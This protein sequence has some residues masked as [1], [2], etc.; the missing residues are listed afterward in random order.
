MSFKERRGLP[1]PSER[2]GI[3]KLCGIALMSS[4]LFIHPSRHIC[5]PDFDLK[6]HISHSTRLQ[7]SPFKL[8]L[9]SSIIPS[10]ISPEGQRAQLPRI[11][12]ASGSWISEISCDLSMVKFIPRKPSGNPSFLYFL[13]NYSLSL[14]IL[15]QQI[16]TNFGFHRFQFFKYKRIS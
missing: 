12:R 8:N 15:R 11:G 5:G 2:N 4:D 9:L 16:G 14:R 10:E 13:S 3:W 6:P 7:R 1:L